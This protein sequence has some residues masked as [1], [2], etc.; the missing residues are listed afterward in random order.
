MFV[1]LLTYKRP[2]SEVERYLAE[3]RA[4]LDRHYAD[5]AFLCS[6]PRKPRTGGVILCRA[7]DRESVEVLTAEDPFRMHGIADYEIIEF[8]P[9]KLIPG[10]EGFLP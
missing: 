4:Y 5:G 9:T 1:I 10:F 2:L 7:A 6:G 8:S 3:H